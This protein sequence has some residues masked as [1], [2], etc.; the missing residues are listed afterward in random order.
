[1]RGSCLPW[2]GLDS[3]RVRVV[4]SGRGW[5]T[6]SLS[7]SAAGTGGGEGDF[8]GWREAVISLYGGSSPGGGTGEARWTGGRGGAAVSEELSN[9]DGRTGCLGDGTCNNGVF[10]RRDFCGSPP[11]SNLGESG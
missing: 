4:C 10:I 3:E 2:L 7:A 1:V 8:E 9:D 6:L 11:K 5:S